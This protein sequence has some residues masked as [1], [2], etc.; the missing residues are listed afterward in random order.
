MRL[1][2]P[3]RYLKTAIVPGSFDPI[4]SGHLDIIKRA[5]A[6]FDTVVIGVAKNV[7]KT[8]MFTVD[9]RVALVRKATAGI[10]NVTVE[11][12]DSLLVEFAALKN[13]HVVVRGLRAVSDF[14][15]E[16]QMAQLNREL[17]DSVETLFMMASPEYAYLS[18]SSVREIAEYGGVV[19][20]LVPPVVEEALNKK[21]SS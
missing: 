14:E 21:F 8:P 12:F 15:H 20:S 17:N 16:F 2:G 4:T 13:A 10:S 3:V 11:E 18:S 5:V 7:A 1:K 9:E 6:L 19:K